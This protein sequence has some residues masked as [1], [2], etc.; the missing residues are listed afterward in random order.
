DVISP[1]LHER[2]H[3]ARP[4]VGVAL[5]LSERRL[6][7]KRAPRPDGLPRLP[8]LVP[9]AGRGMLRGAADPV[10]LDPVAA[11]VYTAGHDRTF[12]LAQSH[13]RIALPSCGLRMVRRAADRAET[14]LA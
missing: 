1:R 14:W 8:R 3:V 2:Q 7:T 10:R 4:A 9:T 6:D 5:I 13:G 11:G 12:S